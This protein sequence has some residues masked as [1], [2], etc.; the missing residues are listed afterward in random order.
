MIIPL[1]SVVVNAF[2]ELRRERKE[3]EK[4][5]F[6]QMNSYLFE[7]E[8]RDKKWYI[9]LKGAKESVDEKLMEYNARLPLKFLAVVS[10]PEST[11]DDNAKRQKIFKD[12]VYG[13][14][15]ILKSV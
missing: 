15:P 3:E 9:C 1:K 10:D 14:E 4:L 12:P 8:E 6:D 13:Y 7:L 2:I 11:N 5:L